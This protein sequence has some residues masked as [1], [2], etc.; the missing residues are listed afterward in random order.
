MNAHVRALFAVT[1]TGALALG[2]T[3]CGGSSGESGSGDTIKVAYWR[4]VDNK[5][6]V[7][8]NYLTLVK[9]QFEKANK[10]K[11]VE[12]VPIQAS[13][14]D[15]YSKIQLMMRSPR[16]APDLVYEDTFLINAD[17]ASGYLLPIDDYLKKWKDWGQFVDTAKAA[18][19]GQDGKTYGVPD[20]T[21][22]RG[23]WYNKELFAKAGLPT[24]WKPKTWDEVLDAA[25]TI[26]KKLPGVTPMN[27]YTGKAA[28]EAATMQ[29]FEM[30]LYG[31]GED[32]LYDPSA[33]KWVVGSKG[34]KDSLGFVDTVF[35]EKLGPDVEDALDANFGSTVATELLPA[36]KLAIDLD[37]SWMGNNWIE[38]GAKPWPE[39]DKVLGTTSMPTQTGQS[40][41][42]VTLS[43]GWTWAIPAKSK[44][45]DVAF[46]FIKSMQTKDNA[47]EYCIRNAGIAV[48]KDVAADPR[49]QKSMPGVDFFTGLVQYTHYRPALPVYPQVSTAIQEAME[50]V[51]TGQASPEKAASTYDEAVKSATDG[52]VESRG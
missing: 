18:A 47:V 5:S 27:I 31:T 43:G 30:L 51:T 39:W 29:G 26:K 34:F 13:E 6:R 25:R 10:G 22:T 38:T 20:G 32:P 45:P 12:L 11:K 40:P 3:A 14:N 28:G 36:G 35:K 42:T 2:L 50:A 24:D 23:L 52:A 16:T 48:R 21:D 17:I 8:D 7:M 1:L 15:Y 46:D 41:G 4:Q 49:Y 44:N 9:K 37:G 19:K 33:K